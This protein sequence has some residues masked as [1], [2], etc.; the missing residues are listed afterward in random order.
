MFKSNIK[1][2]DTQLYNTNYK[3]NNKSR[4]KKVYKAQITRRKYNRNKNRLQII[5]Y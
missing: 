4:K 3:M 1:K 5:V 2:I